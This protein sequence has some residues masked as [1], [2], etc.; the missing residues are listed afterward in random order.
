MKRLNTLIRNK[1][2]MIIQEVKYYGDLKEFFYRI[3]LFEF[4][5]YIIIIKYFN[6]Y[7][8]WEKHF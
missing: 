8:L 3:H 5:M 6:I 4:I 7:F 2:L 1:L